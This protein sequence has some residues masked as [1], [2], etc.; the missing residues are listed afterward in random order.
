[1]PFQT[2]SIPFLSLCG[3]LV[4]VACTPP[5]TQTAP[6]PAQSCQAEQYE[7]LLW[8]P[9]SALDG[10]KLPEGTRVIYPNQAVTMDFRKDRLNISVGKSDRIERV[11]CG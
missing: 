1:M 9:K 6:K 7:A 2:I 8:K 4:L 10:Q 3:A 11:Y 5:T